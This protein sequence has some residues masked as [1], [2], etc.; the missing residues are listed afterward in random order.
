MLD[1]CIKQITIN[2]QHLFH[3]VYP[4]YILKLIIMVLFK[5]VLGMQKNLDKSKLKYKKLGNTV[6]R[7]NF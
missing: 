7:N 4:M 3:K 1:K 6:G 2:A 5:C